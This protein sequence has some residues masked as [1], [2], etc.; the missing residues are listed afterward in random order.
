VGNEFGLWK[1]QITH[2][3]LLENSMLEDG[4]R[5]KQ[6]AKNEYEAD[7]MRV[8][9]SSN[10][11]TGGLTSALSLLLP[12]HQFV[13][14]PY[15]ETRE[16][17]ILEQL[18]L[19]DMWLFSGPEE[20]GLETLNK[21]NNANLKV[22]RFPELY[23]NAF[24]PDQVYAWMPDGSLVE[25]ATGPYNSAIT[26]WAWQHE[27]TYEQSINLMRPKVFQALG[28]HNRWQLSVDRLKYDFLSH[29]SFDY[30]D[31]IVP[32]QRAG[33]FMHTVN[34]PKIEA[35]AQ[36]ARLLATQID[37]EAI[38]NEFSIE[39]MMVDGLFMASCSW[40]VYPSIANSLGFKGN[41][42]WKREDHQVLRLDEFVRESFDKYD[43][44]QPVDIDCHELTWPIFDQVLL[45]ASE[46]I[47]R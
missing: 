44:Q 22:Q 41:F 26:L 5:S 7:E 29:T 38:L 27:L 3:Q 6:P 31:F 36:M 30:R 11:M 33:C 34:H 37:K 20:L 8:V 43:A 17:I 12:G 24:H 2:D 45:Q 25:S 32:L 15:V 1:P 42:L 39:E 19:A 4:Y 13:P 14:I 10:C 16:E 28:Y 40:S 9:I 21:L 46:G 18:N 47:R 23:F 35:L